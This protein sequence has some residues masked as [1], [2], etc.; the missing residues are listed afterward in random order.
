[1]TSLVVLNS[2]KA[3]HTHL[4]SQLIPYPFLALVDYGSSDCFIDFGFVSS[5]KLPTREITPLPLTLIDST[6]NHFVSQITTLPIL[7]SCGYVVPTEFFVTKL[8]DSSPTVLGFNWLQSHNPIID[9]RQRT[10]S[11]KKHNTTIEN[12]TSIAP[13]TD[14]RNPKPS[15]TKEA[16]TVKQPLISLI[17]AVAFNHT[18]RA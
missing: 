5:H 4:H 1:M 10:I 6:V 14:P 8:D 17:N 13:P 7:L 18:C 12:P 3:L 11:I 16:L 15:K 9:W 2:P